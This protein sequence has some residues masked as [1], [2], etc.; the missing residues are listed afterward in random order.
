MA[1]AAFPLVPGVEEWP[2]GGPGVDVDHSA[3]SVIAR[4][5]RNIMIM[6]CERCF[7][8][9]GDGESIVRLAHID[10]ALPGGSIRWVHSYLHTGSAT[11]CVA[12]R[13]A[14]HERPDLGAWDP[15]RG[16][17]GRRA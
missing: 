12:E 9:I 8:P 15:A 14:P 4:P 5:E 6:L 10:E 17:G 11:Q 7:A 13:S 2:T 1:D 16:I 3:P